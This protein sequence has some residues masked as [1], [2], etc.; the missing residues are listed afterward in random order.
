MT[1]HLLPGVIDIEEMYEN[2]IFYITLAHQIDII[3]VGF[4]LRI[5]GLANDN[6]LGQ[7]YFNG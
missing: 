5:S 6:K 1:V 4:R 2:T 3:E 7:I